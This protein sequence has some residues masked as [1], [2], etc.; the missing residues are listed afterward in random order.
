M[1]MPVTSLPRGEASLTIWKITC[2]ACK[3]LA[4]CR[5]AL[6]GVMLI[7]GSLAPS[8]FQL[9]VASAAGWP[10]MECYL[11]AERLAAPLLFHMCWV[12]GFFRGVFGLGFFLQAFPC[13]Q[14]P[15]V[16]LLLQISFRE[17]V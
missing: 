6:Q 12:V 16:A 17:Q 8:L 1:L 15:V 2:P 13:F 5:W 14:F 10:R 3:A 9:R 4:V 11:L 7:R